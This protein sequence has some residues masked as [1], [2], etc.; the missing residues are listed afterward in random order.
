MT[1]FE[2]IL[3]MASL[4]LAGESIYMLPYMRKTFGTSM[5]E[6]FDV[7][8]TQLGF[9]NSMFGILALVSYFAGG[10]LADRFSV[11]KLLCFSLVATGAGG[12]YMATFPGYFM[13]LIVHAFWGVT[14]ILTFWAAL[15]KATRLWG[16]KHD[17][18]KTFGILACGRGFVALLLSSLATWTFAQFSETSTGLMSVILVYAFG[19]FVA[20][21]FVWFMV[22]EQFEE[23]ESERLSSQNGK[24]AFLK[25]M[26]M[27]TV[28]LQ[29]VIIFVA[30][31]LYI[32]T[33]EFPAFAEKGFHQDK[34]F[35]AQL[36]LFRD[37]FRPLSA[38]VAGFLADRVQPGRAVSGCFFL[39][40][41]MLTFLS[42]S[43]S[44][45]DL[46]WL[47]WIQVAVISIGVF[48]LRGIYYALLEEGN[49]PRAYTGT[50]VGI[51]STI[52]YF[53]D[54]F[55]YPLAGWFVDT[56]GVLGYRYFFFMLAVL[57]VGGLFCTFFLTKLHQK[58]AYAST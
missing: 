9:L 35:S 54:I 49:I 27:P 26:R 20:A 36:G 47:L 41:C 50:A 19:N 6:T 28:W 4:I 38:I 8:F 37:L 18:G 42:L 53:P 33:F 39:V 13:L 7:S 57:S 44:H 51:I 14:S 22:P 30:Y 21:A 52:G 48:A 43:P 32:G 10:W 16:G 55:G 1:K 40:A 17:Q 46:L 2:R 29:S 24:H 31:M 34:V 58:E 25:V 15:I 56:Y 45:V 11:R 3:Y 23:E 12:L 5:V